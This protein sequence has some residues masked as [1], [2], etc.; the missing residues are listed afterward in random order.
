MTDE[1]KNIFG[2]QLR[3]R[4]NELN[5]TT[6]KVALDAEV[7]ESTYKR[8][9]AGDGNPRLDTLVRI[10]KCLKTDL[11]SVVPQE[12]LCKDSGIWQ[13]VRKL[14]SMD[15]KKMNKA[16]KAI[17]AMLDAMSDDSIILQSQSQLK[18]IYKDAA[19]TITGN[20][21]TMLFLGGKESTTLKE[22][23]ET[24][25]KETID[26]YNTSDTR[27]QS[28]SYGLNY[29]KTGKELMSRDELAVMDGNK[30]ILQLRGVRPFYSDKFDITKHKRYKQL[31]DYDKK[32]EFHVEEYM[33][34]QMEVRLDPEEQ[35]DLYMYEGSELEEQSNNE[36]EGTGHV[37]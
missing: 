34:H 36:N 2:N 18:T 27:G 12:H 3:E 17:L 5:L 6:Q 13:I 31:S 30:C 25:G 8:L 23:S 19:E 37:T 16:I 22:I 28:R 29:Q 1:E 7:G 10:A 9:E 24:L 32:N 4:R 20:C 26:L 33:K 14:L 35:F 11:N 15:K 21:D